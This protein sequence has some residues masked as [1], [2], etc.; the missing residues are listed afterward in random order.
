MFNWPEHGVR[1]KISHNG[2][3]E[4]S[5]EFYAAMFE[6]MREHPAWNRGYYTED[7]FPMGEEL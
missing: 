2:L 4:Y 1:R 5:P 7:F 3:V 6:S